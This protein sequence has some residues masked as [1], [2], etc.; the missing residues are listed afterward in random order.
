[1]GDFT[2]YLPDEFKQFLGDA[3][4]SSIQID[5]LEIKNWSIA[6]GVKKGYKV[7]YGGNYV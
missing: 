4:Y 2:Y 3:G 6:M 5:V 1:M 7:M